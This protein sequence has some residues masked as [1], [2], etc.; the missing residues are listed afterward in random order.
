MSDYA[1][2]DAAVYVVVPKDDTNRTLSLAR[3]KVEGMCVDMPKIR[4]SEYAVSSPVQVSHLSKDGYKVRVE[5]CGIMRDRR[6]DDVVNQW[7]ALLVFL[8]NKFGCEPVVEYSYM[9]ENMDAWLKFKT[10][11]EKRMH[12]K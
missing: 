4:G 6:R 8:R 11:R 5:A 1:Y 9:T 3:S 12:R 7:R 10:K 2:I